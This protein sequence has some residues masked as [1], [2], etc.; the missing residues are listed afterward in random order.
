MAYKTEDGQIFNYESDAQRHANELAAGNAA[1]AKR[2]AEV[3]AL[4]I[5]TR[6]GAYSEIKRLF[7]AQ[8][9]NGII[10]H[11]E[12]KKWELQYSHAQTPHAG[13]IHILAEA[14]INND[15]F[16]AFNMGDWGEPYSHTRDEPKDGQ[17]I[18]NFAMNYGKQMWEKQNGRAMTDADLHKA[19]IDFLER[20]MKEKPDRIWWND[21]KDWEKLTGKKLSK[22]EQIRI[23]GKIFHEEKKTSSSSSSSGDQRGVFLSI[24]FGLVCGLGSFLTLKMIFN[25]LSGNGIN[26]ITI[27]AL[28]VGFITTFIAWRYKNNVLFGL[29]L[30]IS[31]IGYLNLFGIIGNKTPKAKTETTQSLAITQQADI[32]NNVNFRKDPSTG[33]N[34]IRQLKKGDTVTLTGETVEGWTQI[35]HNGDTGWVSSE[36]LKVWGDK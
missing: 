4:N 10:K 26:I 33:D 36:F 27:G 9:W 21:V 24:V 19:H 34:I 17:I 3:N 5:S 1:Y 31:V 14:I 13:R 30:V 29:M 6:M 7:N 22:E 18:C 16:T 23:A 20:K 2:A 32:I 25:L 8:D 28:I 15:Y 35:T 12:E 11:Y